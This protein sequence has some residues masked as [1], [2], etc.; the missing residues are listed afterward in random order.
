MRLG[1][2]SD[3]RDRRGVAGVG[4]GTSGVD[5]GRLKVKTEIQKVYL[6]TNYSLILEFKIKNDI[7]IRD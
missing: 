4:V 3:C 6:Q 2:A 7:L 1:S 5:S